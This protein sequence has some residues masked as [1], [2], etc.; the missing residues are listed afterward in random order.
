MMQSIDGK[1]ACDM[2]DKISGDEYYTALDSLKCTAFIEGKHSYQ[3]HYCGFDAFKNDI[4]VENYDV[5]YIY[6]PN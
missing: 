2:V 1:I 4:K 3:I 5:I 6:Y